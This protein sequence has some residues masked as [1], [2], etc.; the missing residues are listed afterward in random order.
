MPF[1]R[2]FIAAGALIGFA[3]AM[4]ASA[5][6]KSFLVFDGLLYKGKPNLGAVGMTPIAGINSPA[7][8]NPS[9]HVV[10][11]EAVRAT[12]KTLGNDAGLVYLDYELW[13]TYQAPPAEVSKNIEM[14]SKVVDIAREAAPHA[15]FG[16]Y[17]LLPCREYW[18]VVN[19]DPAKF[20]AWEACN[21]Q[22]D[23]L[24][25]RVDVIFPSVYT[26]YNDQNAW[27]KFA[28]AQLQAARRYGKPVY[29]FLWPEFHPSNAALK[30]KNVP[31]AFWRHE[32]EFCKAHADGIVIWG[33]W[34][35]PWDEQAAWWLETKAFLAGLSAR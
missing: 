31:A 10:E 27:D 28:T 5:A 13:P 32:L 19:N 11:D 1:K 17:G 24:A 25:K 30:G 2:F 18:G 9:P 23:Q 33:G 12:F 22:L 29:A 26:F 6:D 3:A 8:A 14:L 20:K 34:Q 16:Y 21:A 35:E 7:S 15:K 4:S